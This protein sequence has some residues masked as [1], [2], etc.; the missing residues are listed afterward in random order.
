MKKISL[1]IFVLLSAGFAYCV[2]DLMLD[3]IYLDE[4]NVN[5]RAYTDDTGKK[6]DTSEVKVIEKNRSNNIADFLVKEPEISLKRK[7][8]FGDS[9][10]ILSIRGQGSKRILMNLDGRAINSTGTVGGNYID[11]GTI[12]LDNIDKIEIIKGGSSVEYGN[13]AL[14]GVINAYTARPDKNARF[15]AYGTA[16]GWGSQKDYH[17]IRGS[18]SKQLGEL[19]ISVGVSHQAAD[20][21]LRNNDYSSFHLAPKFF[22][23]TPGGGELIFGYNYSETRRGLIRSNRNDGDPTSDS[24]PDVAGYNSKIDGDFPLSSG[25]Y[26]AG[27]SPTPSMTVIGDNAHWKKTKHMLDVQFTQPISDNAYA[28]ISA[29]KNIEDRHEK[30]YA[31]VEARLQAQ[32]SPM[33]TF[34]PALTDDGDLVLDRKVVVDRSYGG[35]AKAEIETARHKLLFGVETK[36]LKSGG[37]FVKHI[38]ENY[39]IGGPNG[40]TGKMASSN[41]G[42][43]AVNNS[44]FISE[45]YK[46]N[47]VVSFNLGVRYDNFSANQVTKDYD[48]DVFT[49]KLGVS[50]NLTDDDQIAFYAYRNFRTPTIPELYWNSNSISGEIEYLEGRSFKGETANALDVVLK[51]TF[52][53]AGYVRLSG[54]YYD[55]EDYIMHKP[56]PVSYST[57]KTRFAAYNA[58]AKFMG[59]TADTSYDI[60]KDL[61]VRAGV[62]YQKTKKENDPADPD[63][64]LEKVDY[65]PDYKIVL[66]TTWQA[67]KNVTVDFGVNYIGKRYYARSSTDVENL[68]SYT[69]LDGSVKVKISDSVTWELYAENITDTDYEESWGY[70]SMGFNMGTSLRWSM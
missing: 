37:I 61:S 27:G 4:I 11:F 38:D 66:G 68:G 32:N 67:V 3:T 39:N 50:L 1:M 31:D 60:V 70:P 7:A 13:N 42:S 64:I 63:G 8:A 15:S 14:G 69:T 55:V 23:G 45:K 62:T 41:D 16:G 34:D 44:A 49:P 19:G 10:D 36:H 40:W 18:Y 52:P 25:E 20:E 26:F 35:K 6:L 2:D 12:P 47:D 51:H 48:D 53:G 65:I 56:V 59:V 24:N 17:N 29:Y 21:Y 54:F 58:D 33:D 57:S 46:L 5:E 43:Y 22:I 30:N 9:G 28:E